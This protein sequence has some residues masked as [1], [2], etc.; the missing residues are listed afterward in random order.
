MLPVAV[1]EFVEGSYSSAL[2]S[3]RYPGGKGLVV[4]II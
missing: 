2:A 1:H 3:V 4:T